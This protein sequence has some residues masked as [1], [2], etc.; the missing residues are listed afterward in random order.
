MDIWAI[1]LAARQQVTSWCDTYPAGW[2]AA[3]SGRA[4]RPLFEISAVASPDNYSGYPAQD[5][6][7]E[8]MTEK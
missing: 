2:S 6:F 1:V 5:Y 3:A 4:L 7:A 8:G